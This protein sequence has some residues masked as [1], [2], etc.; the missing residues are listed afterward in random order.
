MKTHSSA[1]LDYYRWPGFYEN[2]PDISHRHTD[3]NSFLSHWPSS[4]CSS[5][6][7]PSPPCLPASLDFCALLCALL[8]DKLLPLLLLSFFVFF[9][10]I[11][12][13]FFFNFCLIWSEKYVLKVEICYQNTK[14]HWSAT[15]NHQVPTN[16]EAFIFINFFFF[17]E[18]G[19]KIFRSCMLLFSSASALF[20]LFSRNPEID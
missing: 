13:F 11:L 5:R 9:N 6:R 7:T 16:S 1:F 10:A 20:D 2:V 4:L 15:K 8:R 3:T 14:Q 12:I 17:T 19:K 18:C